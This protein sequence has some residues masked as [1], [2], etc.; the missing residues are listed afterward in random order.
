LILD[1]NDVTGITPYLYTLVF[2]QTPTQ[3]C[4]LWEQ[5]GK[6]EFI[7]GENPFSRDRRGNRN[8]QHTVVPWSQEP[9]RYA[10]SAHRQEIDIA[11]HQWYSNENKEGNANLQ[12][13]IKEL[14]QIAVGDKVD[15]SRDTVTHN[16]TV[17]FTDNRYGRSWTVK[18][19]SRFPQDGATISYKTWSSYDTEYSSLRNPKEPSCRDVR[20]AMRRIVRYIR[21]KG[22]ITL[23]HSY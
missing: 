1:V 10:P 5:I 23:S 13:V 7:D 16:L 9:G 2:I 22:P 11:S 4:E 3:H 12:F 19:P 14:E 21:E 17:M 15:I 20:E 18:F 6:M 8:Q